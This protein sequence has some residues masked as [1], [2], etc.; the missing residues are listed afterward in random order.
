M[1]RLQYDD[2]YTEWIDSQPLLQFSDVE[3][4]DAFARIIT[5]NVH[6]RYR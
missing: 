1:N 6:N 4:E 3:E 2:F 5:R